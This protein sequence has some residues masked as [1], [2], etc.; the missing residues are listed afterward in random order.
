MAGELDTGSATT[1]FGSP[2]TLGLGPLTV[3]PVTPTRKG[4]GFTFSQSGFRFLVKPS[5]IGSSRA[6]FKL[7]FQGDLT[8]SFPLDGDLPV[9]YAD[10]A[11]FIGGTPELDDGKFQ[12]KR[13]GEIHDPNFNLVKVAAK[14]PAG[15]ANDKLALVVA[16]NEFDGGPT[17]PFDVRLEF[18]DGFDVTLPA[19]SFRRQG[20][21]FTLK[22]PAPGITKA[23][24]DYDSGLMSFSG[25]GLDLG[26]F[27]DGSNVVR[28]AVSLG[29]DRRA[30]TVRLGKNGVALRY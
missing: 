19:S 6:K 30:V 1:A 3:G 16:L 10:M 22:R 9:G 17:V 23:T 18:G 15:E 21:R 13:G 4:T 11:A 7:A 2:V 8:E 12:L 24:L 5:P 26:A 29:A 20:D 14:V 27:A 28:I 25:K